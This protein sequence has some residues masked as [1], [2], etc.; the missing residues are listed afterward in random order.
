MTLIFHLKKI[1]RRRER[2]KKKIVDREQNLKRRLYNESLDSVNY[3]IRCP[4]PMN[5]P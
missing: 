2:I 5:Y 3:V 1:F 4:L